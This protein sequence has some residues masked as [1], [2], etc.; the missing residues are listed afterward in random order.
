LLEGIGGLSKADAKKAH[1]QSGNYQDSAMA[2]L[3]REHDNKAVQLEDEELDDQD[4]SEDDSTTIPSAIAKVTSLLIYCD[5]ARC[6][7]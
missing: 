3:G 4:W 1:L 6:S 5:C 7:S 2:P